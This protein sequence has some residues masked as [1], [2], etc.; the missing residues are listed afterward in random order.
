L[1]GKGGFSSAVGGGRRPWVQIP[2]LLLLMKVFFWIQI[3]ILLL[4]M[5]VF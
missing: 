5:K 3:P 4:L 1:Y 2:I